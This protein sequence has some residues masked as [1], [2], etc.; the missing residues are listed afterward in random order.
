M[1]LVCSSGPRTRVAPFR[2]SGSMVV[3][4]R[5]RCRSLASHFLHQPARRRM[6][7]TRLHAVALVVFCG[8]LAH[9]RSMETV[10]SYGAQAA[11]GAQETSD[12]SWSPGVQKAPETSPPLSPADEMKHFYLPPGYRVELV[13]SEPLVQDPIAVD[14][15]ADGR[16]VG[17]RV[18]GIRARISRT[19]NRTWSRSAGSSCS[20]TPTTTARWTSAPCSPT[21][22]FRGVRSRRS[23]TA[24]S[25]TNRRTSG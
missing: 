4:R 6:F 21:G 22:S 12:R 2:R 24:S 1:S 19:R 5:S 7:M 10:P 8:A 11:P 13:A 9:L 17:G 23:T 16:H 20:K 18:S 15:D 3:R 14:W 25:S